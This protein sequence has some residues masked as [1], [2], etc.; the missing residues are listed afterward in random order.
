MINWTDEQLELKNIPYKW[1]EA[2]NENC[3]EL[4]E[5]AEFSLKKW[6]II[7]DMGILAVPIKHE[8]GGLQ[9]DVLTTMLVLET[10]GNCCEDAGLNFVVSSHIVSTAI[11]LQKFGTPKQQEKYLPSLSTGKKIGAHAITEPGGGSGV[12]SMRT[13]AIKNDK[14]Y[15][16]DGSKMFISNGPI[17]DLLVV[18]ASTIKDAGA[19]EGVSAFLL[20]K[21]TPGL[22]T[23]RPISKMGLRTAPL[24]EIYFDNCQI[25]PD[26]LLGKEG[27]GFAIFNY[28][29]KWEVLCSFAINIGEME[30]LLN[31]CIEFSKIR[32][33]YG[34]PLS[35]FQAISHKIADIKIAL[36]SSRALLYQ[37]GQRFQQ[38]K[39]A[40]VDIAIA[41]IV[42]SESYVKAAQE[43]I[44][45]F[46][47][48]GY[49]QET[50]IEKYLRNSV[51]SKIYSGTS[52]IQKNTIASM[53]GL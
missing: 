33:R 11:P 49:M 51:A 5:H 48:Y 1:A 8:Y 6:E 53:I 24:C 20:D 2:L 39:N 50:G 19:L 52:E 38:G 44:Q 40:T 37:A 18:Y 7:K 10:L 3:L 14:G 27:Q 16:L 25:R 31:R 26:Q 13:R 30:Y 22:S 21:S 34:K 9:Q 42:T 12:L 32:K 36:E 41:K 17:A 29:M 47:T 45:I 28:V 15:L 43:A 46:G 35:E 4:D 23:G